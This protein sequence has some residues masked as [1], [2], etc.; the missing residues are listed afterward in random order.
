MLLIM[1]LS[2]NSIIRSEDNISGVGV[3]DGGTTSV[4]MGLEVGKTLI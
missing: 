3:D 4:L 1:M 2:D